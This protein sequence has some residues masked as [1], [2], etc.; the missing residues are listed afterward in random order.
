MLTFLKTLNG[1]TYSIEYKSTDSILD[2]KK[3]VFIKYDIP[4]D[5]Q[6]VIIMGKL[7]PDDSLFESYDPR[8]LETIHL[9]IR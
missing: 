3:H 7:A 6:T 9:I 4:I 5:S 8:R 1:T 2:I